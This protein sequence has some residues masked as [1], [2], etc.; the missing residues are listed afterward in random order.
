MWVLQG[1]EAQ[2]LLFAGQRAKTWLTNGSP[3]RSPPCRYAHREGC[4]AK[5]R[6]AERPPTHY[7]GCS[8]SPERRFVLP[9]ALPF[10]FAIFWASSYAAAKI[11]LADITPYAF[12]A[13]RL[14]IAAA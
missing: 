6:R 13:I 11:G 1:I 9:A 10:M 2:K 3:H 5:S 8:Q 12:V 7:T 4:F 14:A